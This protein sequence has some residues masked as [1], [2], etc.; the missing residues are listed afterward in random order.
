MIA[1][2][3]VEHRGGHH[4]DREVG[5]V[6]L[7]RRLAV[8]RRPTCERPYGP[9]REHHEDPD[10]HRRRRP[11]DEPASASRH[12]R[13]GD[14]RD[15]RQRETERC[16]EH[17]AGVRHVDEH[18]RRAER[19]QSEE[20]GRDEER[21]GDEEEAGILMAARFE[22]G[23]HREGRAD[24][25]GA[26]HQPEVGRLLL[27][28]ELVIDGWVLDE[29]P[30]PEHRQRDVHEPDERAGRE[31][32]GD[33]R[34]TKPH[35]RAYDQRSRFSP[36][37]TEYRSGRGSSRSAPGPRRPSARSR[38]VPGIVSR[39]SASSI[40]RTSPTRSA[41]SSVSSVQV[42]SGPKPLRGSSDK[43]SS[44][45][46]VPSSHAAPLI[47]DSA[48]RCSVPSMPSPCGNGSAGASHGATYSRSPKSRAPSRNS[49]AIKH[50]DEH[51]RS[52][53]ARATASR[54]RGTRYVTG[55]NAAT[56]AAAAPNSGGDQERRAERARQ[57]VADRFDHAV[58]R[59]AQVRVVI[60]A[61]LVERDRRI[62]HLAARRVGD[63]VAQVEREVDL[64]PQR[65]VGVEDHRRWWRR[66][67]SRVAVSTWDARTG[68]ITARPITK[69][70]CRAAIEMVAARTF[71]FL[72]RHR[73]RAEDTAQHTEADAACE[74][75]RG[76]PAAAGVGEE[77]ER[78][79]T[80]GERDPAGRG[81]HA[82]RESCPE[83]CARR[84]RRAGGR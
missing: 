56:T 66:V 61:A 31:P 58:T 9:Q 76:G 33:H 32:L 62:R 49:A 23:F 12:H 21:N 11:Y 81:G 68:A 10:E 27:P 80:A 7:D 18:G 47:A 45:R 82:H 4:E 53:A 2:A 75:R 64:G 70:A 14:R 43:I 22:R 29:Q 30:Q 48:M 50:D 36:R 71:G 26:E 77:G 24:D 3:A 17:E 19:V 65:D 52:P 60:G 37:G 83:A 6:L 20:P 73:R 46:P 8:E 74:E 69:P 13:R 72:R 63:E 55:S 35:N 57:R 28:H 59:V 39:S 67:A 1:V 79:E 84:P 78:D 44:S 38:R 25:R 5:A 40:A 54:V 42:T 16:R 41:S 34:C 15:H 51:D